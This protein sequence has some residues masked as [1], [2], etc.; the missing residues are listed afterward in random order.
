MNIVDWIIIIS[1]CA[2][3]VIGY[4]RGFIRQAIQLLSF[5]AAFFIAYRYHKEFAPVLE[6]I[7]PFNSFK[8]KEAFTPIH[9]AEIFNLDTV[10]YRAV[11]FGILFFGSKLA[12]LLIGIVLNAFVS[13][14]GLAVVNRWSGALL[15]FVEITLLL[16]IAIQISTVL[17]LTQW[18]HTLEKSSLVQ[19]TLAKT[20]G[21]T[22]QLFDWWSKD[23]DEV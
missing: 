2:A 22:E 1:L 12:L 4:Y 16:Y 17:P 8:V 7:V 6:R 3:F 11:A 21:I 14:P 9:I 20:P 13:L 5:G 19:W 18:Q 23:L 15:S 10:I